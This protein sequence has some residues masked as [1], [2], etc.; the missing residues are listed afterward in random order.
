VHVV[1]RDPDADVRV[2]GTTVSRHHARLVVTAAEVVLE[3]LASKNGIYLGD[4]RVTATVPLA[5]GDA[6][7]FGDVLVTFHT[8]TAGDSTDTQVVASS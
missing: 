6:V 3:D 7:R 1:G 8:A 5:D 2:D 4:Q